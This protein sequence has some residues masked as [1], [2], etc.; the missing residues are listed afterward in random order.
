[1]TADPDR[2]T[3]VL[4]Y[5]GEI[6]EETG[7]FG[8][9]GDR[10]VIQEGPPRVLVQVAMSA[11]RQGKTLVRAYITV[12]ESLDPSEEDVEGWLEEYYRRGR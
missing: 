9:L 10:I 4:T 8:E 5:A 7:Q 2:R 3:K 6:S 1:M 11:P 12:P